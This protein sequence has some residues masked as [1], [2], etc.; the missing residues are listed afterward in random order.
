[1][2]QRIAVLTDI[3]LRLSAIKTRARLS[4]HLHFIAIECIRGVQ[5]EL[6]T[7]IH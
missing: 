3:L 6:V 2:N 1:M 4:S 7:A 5:V